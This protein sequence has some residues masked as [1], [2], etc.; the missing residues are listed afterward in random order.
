MRTKIERYIS[1]WEK[2]CYKEGIPDE[3]PVRIEQLHKAPSYKALVRA[4]FRN[5]ST[6]KGLG[7]TTEKC[8]TYHEFKR[9]ELAQRN[10]PVQLKL[11]N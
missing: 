6:L 11:F 9:I 3:V 5:D 4:I 1:T 7:I 10:K 2:R 8:R